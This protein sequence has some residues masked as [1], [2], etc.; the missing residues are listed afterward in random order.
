MKK[1]KFIVY[2]YISLNKPKFEKSSMAYGCQ[3]ICE[4]GK[5]QSMSFFKEQRWIRKKCT[6]VALPGGTM[7]VIRFKNY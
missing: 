4:N 1:V 2:T 6:S 3:E 5:P 7:S